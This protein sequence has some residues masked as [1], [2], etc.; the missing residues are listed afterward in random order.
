QLDAFGLQINQA[1]VQA[2]PIGESGSWSLQINSPLIVGQV[3]LPQNL[4]TQPIVGEFQRFRLLP[5]ASKGD[6]GINPGKIPAVDL[7][8]NN[9]S[10]E[11]RPLGTVT[12]TTVPQQPNAMQISKVSISFG[13]F[14]LT[15]SGEWSGGGGGG[16]DH[17]TLNGDFKSGDLGSV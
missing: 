17:T 3:T 5:A 11:N 14:N 10:Y 6:S 15:S 8:F 9:F 12:V 1:N 4:E 7:I 16:G 2:R 13:N